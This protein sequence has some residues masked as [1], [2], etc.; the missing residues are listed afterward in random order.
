MTPPPDRPCLLT[1][2]TPDR[3]RLLTG[4]PHPTPPCLPY[5]MTVG[6]HSILAMLEV[7]GETTDASA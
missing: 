3:P 1:G 6:T 7:N 5:L 4:S 2:H